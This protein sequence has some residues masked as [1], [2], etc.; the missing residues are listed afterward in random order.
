MAL[1]LEPCWS[2]SSWEVG[3]SDYCDERDDSDSDQV[4]TDEDG[5]DGGDDDGIM[6]GR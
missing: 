2:S 1:L 5:S 4:R 3:S 6:D